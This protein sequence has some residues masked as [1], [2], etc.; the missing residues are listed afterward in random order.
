MPTEQDYDLIFLRTTDPF[1]R[2]TLATRE[3]IYKMGAQ[4]KTALIKERNNLTKDI[5]RR[6][7]EGYK[8]LKDEN[9]QMQ[10]DLRSSWL[11]H[12]N[13][14]DAIMKTLLERLKR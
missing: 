4:A 7:N 2:I 9:D 10:R 8:K 1:L 11:D 12:H 5:T 13:E 14:I 6:W 3:Q